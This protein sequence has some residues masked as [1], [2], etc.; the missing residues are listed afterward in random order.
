MYVTTD[1]K[2]P[3]KHLV[4][5][6][7]LPQEK[8]PSRVTGVFTSRREVQFTIYEKIDHWQTNLFI[9]K[10]PPNDVGPYLVVLVDNSEYP[11]VKEI[12]I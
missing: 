7:L 10:L 4:V 2:D 1:A 9:F 5:S 3:G 12:E 6:P 11:T 8:L